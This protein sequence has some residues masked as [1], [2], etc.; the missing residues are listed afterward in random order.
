MKLPI[1]LSVP[2]AGWRIPPEVEDICILSQKDILEDGDVGADEIYYSLKEEFAEF[3]TIDVGRPIVDLNR[4]A[5]DFRKDGVIKTHTCW[6]VPVYKVHPTQNIIDALLSRY[7]HPYHN[8]LKALAKGVKLGID[9]HTMAA[10]GPPVG[11]DPGKR[12]PPVCI[13]N[14][15]FTCPRSWLESLAVSLELSLGKPVSLNSPFQGGYIIRS[16]ASEMPWIQIEFSRAAFLTNAQKSQALM[17]ALAGWVST[18]PS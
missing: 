1:L 9:A 17:R 12:R 5:D 18:L 6:E 15:G 11:P 10:E 16:H 2:H 3:V 8:N 13:S 7:Y 4:A 14:A